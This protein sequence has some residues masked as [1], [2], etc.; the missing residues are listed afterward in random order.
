MAAK[1]EKDTMMGTAKSSLHRVQ[2]IATRAASAAAM[3]AA[4]AA[5]TS[6][7]NAF[8]RGER[9]PKEVAKKKTVKRTERNVFRA[10]PFIL[11]TMKRSLT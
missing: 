5:V 9:N 8:A 11:K 7:M 4:V 1:R 2:T 6:V 10:R 3:A